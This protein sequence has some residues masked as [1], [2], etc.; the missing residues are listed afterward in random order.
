M[1][2]NNLK[3]YIDGAWVV[4]HS[5]LTLDVIDPSTEEAYTS[6]AAGDRED[7]NAAVAAARRAFDAFSRTTRSERLALL[8]R[9]LMAYEERYEDMAQA[10]SF[11]MGAP[12][13]L[14]RQSQARGGQAHLEVT[15]EALESYE[16][17]L[18]RGSSKVIREPIGV[19]ALITPWN[20]PI[21]QIVAKVAPALAA[22]CTMVLK[23]SEVSPISGV[24]FAEIMHSAGVPKGVFNMINGT[25]PDVG[26]VMAGHPD[27]DM[28]SF[29]GSTRAGVIVAKVAADTVKR[30][31]QELGGKSPNIILPDADFEAAVTRGV[32]KIMRNTGQSCDAP[33]RM[34]VPAA[35]HDE[36]LAIAK[37][38]AET[39]VVGDPCSESVGMGPLASKAQYEKVRHLI[40]AGIAEG[41]RLVTGGPERPDHLGRGY[42]VRPTIF[43]NVRPGMAIERE[44][45]F[46]PVLCIIPYHDEEEA[47]RIGNNTEY[48]LAA[49]VSSEDREH[50]RTIA[51]RL[52]VGQVFINYAAGDLHVPFGGYKQSGNGREYSDWAISDFTELKAVVGYGQT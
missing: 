3:F 8:R 11:E 22:G 9:I 35:R 5:K 40:K 2:D 49:Y 33:T 47:V 13:T 15:I 39:V 26:Q 31:S 24:I 10:I 29:T 7:V 20:W 37:A 48:G 34:L 19:C 14:A 25:G 43:G 50:A 28:V 27:V 23:P 45:I 46:G 17:S 51:A 41:A 16:F 30:V 52:R 6:I 42:F 44:E 12:I 38:V 36:A 21:N 32:Q 1:T 18:M 4:P